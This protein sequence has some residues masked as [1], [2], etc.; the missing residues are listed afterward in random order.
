MKLLEMASN[1]TASVAEWVKQG[2]PVVTQ[3]QFQKR[4]DLCNACEFFDQVSIDGGGSDETSGILDD[5]DLNAVSMAGASPTFAE[6]VEAEQKVMEDNALGGA[7]A[8]LTTPAFMASLKTTEKA[9]NTAQFIW[10]GANQINGRPAYASNNVTAAHVI[11][12][13][14]NDLVLASFGA[15]DVVS[16][17][18][19]LA[20]T[21]LIRVHVSRH[22]DCAV[23]RGQSFC[24]IA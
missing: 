24:K 7:L 20:T 5:S 10:D 23:R 16:D 18:Y 22:V 1:F 13:N 6:V 8:Y 2:A 15:V 19:S 4:A 3:E 14:F 21:G 17:P 12:G 9:S 11:Y